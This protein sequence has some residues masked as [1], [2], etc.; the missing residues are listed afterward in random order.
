[1][2]KKYLE[3]SYFTAALFIINPTKSCLKLNSGFYGGS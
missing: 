3:R 2:G 1:M